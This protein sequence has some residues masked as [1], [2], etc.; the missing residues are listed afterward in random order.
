MARPTKLTAEVQKRVVDAVEY[1]ATYEFACLYGGIGYSTFREWMLHGESDEAD[2]LD[3]P[4]TE[5]LEAIKMA[6][7]KAV[8]KWLLL[9]EA[10]A[11]EHWQAAA[12]KLERRYPAVFGRKV[13]DVTG[14][15]QPIPTDR[16]ASKLED[17]RARRRKLLARSAAGGEA[18]SGGGNGSQPD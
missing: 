15:E 1:G 11:D 9:I 10:A 17:L 2:G 14:L 16:D 12:W 13:L 6:E 18:I 3:T 5:F 4:F 8:V 7:G